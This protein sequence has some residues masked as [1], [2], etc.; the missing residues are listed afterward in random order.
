MQ[1]NISNDD[2][3][4]LRKIIN[5]KMT[6]LKNKLDGINLEKIEKENYGILLEN[7]RMLLRN[8]SL[9]Y[10]RLTSKHKEMISIEEYNDCL[11]KQNII[12]N[13]QDKWIDLESMK[14]TY[15]KLLIVDVAKQFKKNSNSSEIESV[16]KKIDDKIM[17][18]EQEELQSNPTH[19]YIS[20]LEKKLNMNKSE[21]LKNNKR[22]EN[23]S[24][25]YYWNPSRGGIC[26][27][28]SDDGS[29]LAAASSVN[30]DRHLEEFKNG[31]RNG[32]FK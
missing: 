5:E 3:K 16:I 24:A 18:L 17:E 11:K 12:N 31:K 29:Y 20:K 30:Y 8:I 7:C 27:I 28:V 32:D 9:K 13:D 21:I 22:I 23:E 10:Y 25:T 15:E 26:L 14:V 4:E 19:I 1:E 6:L 2:L